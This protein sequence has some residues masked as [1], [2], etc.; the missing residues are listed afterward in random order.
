VTTGIKNEELTAI[1]GIVS[2]DGRA[3]TLPGGGTICSVQPPHG[4]ENAADPLFMAQ[5]GVYFAVK[6]ASEL[7]KIEADDSLSEIGKLRKIVPMHAQNARAAATVMQ[8]V[9]RNASAAKGDLEAFYA[10]PPSTNDVAS[11]MVDAEARQR[12]RDLQGAALSKFL[13]GLVENVANDPRLER[14][15]VGLV[16]SPLPLTTNAE[17]AV[18]AAWRNL[19][20]ARR[21]DELGKLKARVTLAD[22]AMTISEQALSAVAGRIE[23]TRA[24]LATSSDINA[25]RNLRE[26]VFAALDEHDHTRPMIPRFGFHPEEIAIMRR[27]RAA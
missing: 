17:M 20:E 1:G 22:W 2:Q 19:C 27:A 24:A 16:R 3:V 5:S 10:P 13:G 14:M 25:A 26:S 9:E 18:E 15:V 12:I 7:K 21:P 8:D 23:K 6:V 11:V 4:F